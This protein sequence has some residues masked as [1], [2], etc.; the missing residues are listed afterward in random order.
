MIAF[1]K[2][3]AVLQLLWQTLFG[4]EKHSKIQANVMQ[5]TKTLFLKKKSRMLWTKVVFKHLFYKQSLFVFKF[6]PIAVCY[7]VIFLQKVV[8]TQ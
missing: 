2:Y 6:Q 3:L 4:A 1:E 7:I 5:S 8:V